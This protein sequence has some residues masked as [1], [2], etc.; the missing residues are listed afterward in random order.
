MQPSQADWI[1]IRIE[2]YDFVENQDYVLISLISEIKTTG[3]GGDRRS[4]E[5]FGT[6]T[7]AK[8]LAMVENNRIGSGEHSSR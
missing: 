1:K 4:V 5:Y 8:E 7:M 6:L 3:R 2:T